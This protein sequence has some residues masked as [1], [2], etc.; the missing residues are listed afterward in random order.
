MMLLEKAICFEALAKCYDSYA[1]AKKALYSP[2]KPADFKRQYEIAKTNITSVPNLKIIEN[3][4]DST[5]PFLYLLGNEAL[6][7]EK[8]VALVGTRN[9]SF[10][11]EEECIFIA[12]E[13]LKQRYVICSGL[14]LG[15]D[16][17]AHLAGIDVSRTIAFVP[18]GLDGSVYPD[19][20]RLLFRRV[21]DHGL[22]VSPFINNFKIQKW[23]FMERNK[24]MANHC[25]ISILVESEEEGGGR[26]ECDYALK[27][28]KRVL[29]SS[30]IDMKLWK[31]PLQAEPFSAENLKPKPV[32][33]QLSLF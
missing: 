25:D 2:Y 24:L 23:A 26:K 10:E 12:Q 15:I 22:A 29:V 33:V 32:Y 27:A 13:A 17:L 6:L 1:Q 28:N 8:S 14:A 18:F 31:K 9:P 4:Y 7:K 21:V 19:E 16:T 3:P 30:I 11:G 5:F 20:N